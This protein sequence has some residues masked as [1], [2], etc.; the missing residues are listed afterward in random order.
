MATW[1]PRKGDEP[2]QV[3]AGFGARRRQL[4]RHHQLLGE[5]Q[6]GRRGRAAGRLEHAA[7]RVLDA[8]GHGAADLHR[9]PGQAEVVVGRS[10]GELDRP[11]EHGREVRHVVVERAGAGQVGYGDGRVGGV[12]RPD[13]RRGAGVGAAD[14][15]H[16]VGR[17][18]AEQRV[19]V[20]QLDLA[21]R[22]D[23]GGRDPVGAVDGHDRA[24]RDADDLAVAVQLE[25]D[26]ALGRQL[27]AVLRGAGQRGGRER[28]ELGGGERDPRAAGHLDRGGVEEQHR[29][30][31]DASRVAGRSSEPV[32]TSWRSRRGWRP[33]VTSN[34]WSTTTTSGLSVPEATSSRG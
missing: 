24:P 20:Q 12:R 27:L 18:R 34:G 23:R 2:P 25:A 5:Q 7:D 1:A 4:P 32:P 13:E 11:A 6:D 10:P 17:L 28:L 15:D 3:V 21:P 8:L 19:E 16:Q 29:L 30:E 26:P 9:T 33:K 14:G 22:G 31:L